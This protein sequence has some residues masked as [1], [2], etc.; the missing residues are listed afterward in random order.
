V[1]CAVAEQRAHRLDPKRVAELDDALTLAESYGWQV[2][3]LS[4]SYSARHT[5]RLATAQQT[6]GGCRAYGIEIPPLF[7]HHGF[8]LRRSA[9]DLGCAVRRERVRLGQRRLASDRACSMR[10]RRHLDEAAAQRSRRR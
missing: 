10:V 4:P 6:A 7:E 3:G 1:V 9:E 8:A 2:V 5:T